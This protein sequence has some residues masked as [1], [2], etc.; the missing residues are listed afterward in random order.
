[1]ARIELSDMIAG[2]RHELVEA[3]KKAEKEDLKFNVESIDIE[4]QVTVSVEAEVSGLAKFKFWIFGEVEAGSK[5]G[6]SRETVQTIKL[7]LKPNQPLE[8]SRTGKRPE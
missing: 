2:L 5:A 8:I 7:K 1:M 6:A 3:Q 4:A